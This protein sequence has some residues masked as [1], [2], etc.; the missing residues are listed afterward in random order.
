MFGTQG[1]VLDDAYILLAAN[2]VNMLF[3]AGEK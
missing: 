3:S 2:L 1:M